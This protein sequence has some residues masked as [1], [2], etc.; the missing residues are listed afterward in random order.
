MDRDLREKARE[1]G[2]VGRM[3][4]I[5]SEMSGS[6]SA[7]TCEGVRRVYHTKSAKSQRQ[8]IVALDGIDLSVPRGSVF[9]LLGPNGAGKTTAVRIL[10]TLLTPTSG[11]A[12]VL[13]YDVVREAS[14]V[15]GHIGLI[16]GG[17]RG[18]YGRLSGRQNLLY[19]GAINKMKPAIARARASEVLELVGLTE[20]A[21][22]LTETYSR[23]MRQRLHV[24]RGL[25]TDPEVLFM[26]EP[27]IGLDPIGAQELR[28][29]IPTLAKEG[30]TI[31][32]T[33]HYMFE[34]DQL[35]DHV[36]MLK[37]GSLAAE[38][39]PSDIKR[40]FSKIRVVEVIL[41]APVP[42]IV[43]GI[44]SI[45]G[46]QQV[47]LGVEGLMQRLSVQ[48]HADHDLKESIGT[49]IGHGWIQSL[50]E[51]EPTLEEAYVNLLGD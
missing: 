23:G 37:R 12:F 3:K 49:A 46:V 16:L 9:G 38:G 47:E 25:M 22:S 50:V 42:N 5:G 10:A 35:C 34:A 24:A 13:G 44:S 11:R 48:V 51:R 17:D 27:T 14:R 8:D 15:R 19:H 33:T 7:I 39:T 45:E 41:S 30:K 18:L 43:E 28:R 31:L 1:S 6:V 26:D 20:R 29:L 2:S 4:N 21:D 32:L 40:K 36:V